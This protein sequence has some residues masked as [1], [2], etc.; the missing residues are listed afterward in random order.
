MDG[1]VSTKLALGGFEWQPGV[2]ADAHALLRLRRTFKRPS[3]TMGEA[4]FMGDD[5]RMYDELRGELAALSTD[6][7]Q[8]VLRESASG[9][10][11]FCPLR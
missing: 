11:C 4:W 6:Q 7:L 1:A 5:R 8:G 9:T 3:E 10:S 2:G